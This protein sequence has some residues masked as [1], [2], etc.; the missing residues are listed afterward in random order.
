MG[1]EESTAFVKE[2][3]EPDR[4]VAIEAAVLRSKAVSR[5]NSLCQKAS[6][7]SAC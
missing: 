7:S 4:I 6:D 1:R 3:E 2:Q 5:N